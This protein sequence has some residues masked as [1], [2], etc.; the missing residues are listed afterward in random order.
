[1][2]IPARDCRKFVRVSRSST[3]GAKKIQPSWLSQ[4]I[5]SWVFYVDNL[6]QL[7]DVK[8]ENKTKRKF[9][10]LSK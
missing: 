1:M 8:A 10:K 3:K 2:T 4:W 5:A 9:V 6:Q 7:M